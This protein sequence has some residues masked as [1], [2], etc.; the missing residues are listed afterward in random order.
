M[1][2]D[3]EHVLSGDWLKECNVPDNRSFSIVGSPKFDL[4]EVDFGW[5]RPEKWEYISLDDSL[6]MSLIKSKDS[7]GD[8]EIGLSLP[9]T[10]MNAFATIF[11]HGLSF[12]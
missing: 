11:I 7:N 8:L 4:Y 2:K 9:K 12:M 10:Q 3:K 6:F 1:N 5:G